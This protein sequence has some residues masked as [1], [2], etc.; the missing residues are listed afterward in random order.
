MSCVTVKT[1][2]DSLPEINIKAY[3]KSAS[4]SAAQ[5]DP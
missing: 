4:F 5:A 3:P 2:E 1:L